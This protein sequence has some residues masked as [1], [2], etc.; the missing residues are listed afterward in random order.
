MTSEEI[1]DKVK[2]ILLEILDV[3]EEDIVPTATLADDLGV[4][5]IDLVEILT[6]F[7]NT[8]DLQIREVD[9]ARVKTVQDIID[10]LKIAID[11][12]G[13]AT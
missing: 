3:K 1:G 8:F 13:M 4:T 5:S 2:E 12:K 6:A 10:Y 11:Q 7:A 9:A